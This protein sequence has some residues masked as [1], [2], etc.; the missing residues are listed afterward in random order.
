MDEPHRPA[1]LDP[2]VIG[3]VIGDRH[4]APKVVG[5]EFEERTDRDRPMVI[6]RPPRR[7]LERFS[8]AHQGEQVSCACDRAV[9][10]GSRRTPGGVIGETIVIRG[11]AEDADRWRKAAT[12]VYAPKR[13]VYLLTGDDEALP[14]ALADKRAGE[15]T[16]AYVCQGRV[17]SEPLTTMDAMLAAI[18]S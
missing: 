14:D 18:A 3:G 12:L 11:A 17:C 16:L 6:W 13:Q 7:D 10:A 9:D 5:P 8:G 15:G 1:R 4:L 2:A